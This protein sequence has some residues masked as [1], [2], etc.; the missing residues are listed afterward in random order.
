V[1]EEHPVAEA[2]LDKLA[3]ILPEQIVWSAPIVPGSKLLAVPLEFVTKEHIVC[4]PLF[5]KKN[6]HCPAGVALSL[7]EFP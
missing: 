5:L 3:G 1:P 4:V 7:L 6:F 2:E